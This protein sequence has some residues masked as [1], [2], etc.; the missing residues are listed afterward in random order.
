MA[1]CTLQ[2]RS[3]SQFS[4]TFHFK[5]SMKCGPIKEN[6]CLLRSIATALECYLWKCLHLVLTPSSARTLLWFCL[7][8]GIIVA[9]HKPSADLTLLFLPFSPFCSSLLCNFSKTCEKS[10]GQSQKTL[11]FLSV[12]RQKL[13]IT[14]GVVVRAVKLVC[15]KSLVHHLPLVPTKNP[16]RVSTII[17]SF[18]WLLRT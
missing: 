17:L 10:N 8:I 18:Y 13:L 11:L 7:P 9:S 6:K 3:T 4:V 1:V 12:T 2:V 15:T 5:F 16:E 14:R